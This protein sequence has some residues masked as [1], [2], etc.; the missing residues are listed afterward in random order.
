MFRLN[1]SYQINTQVLKNLLP[2]LSKK[3]KI[4][5]ENRVFANKLTT[6][7]NIFK[8]LTAHL[9]FQQGPNVGDDNLLSLLPVLLEIFKCMF[10]RS[11]VNGYL[12]VINIAEKPTHNRILMNG[13]SCATQ[14][15]LGP[16]FK[17]FW[18]IMTFIFIFKKLTT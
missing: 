13:T 18:D 17:M 16:M 10:F 5:V 11:R 9:R 14:R 6:N 4:A 7:W 2:V 12:L 8:L 3:I 1:S 15:C